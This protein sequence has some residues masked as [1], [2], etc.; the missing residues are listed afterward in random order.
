MGRT[1]TTLL[2]AATLAACESLDGNELG[3]RIAQPELARAHTG[4]SP[5]EVRPVTAALDPSNEQRTRVARA[6]NRGTGIFV[7]A[8]PER[9]QA[10]VTRDT[11]EGVTFNAENADVKEVVRMVLEDLLN[12][13][14]I[15]DPAIRG[16]ITIHTSR[17]V[18]VED[19]PAILDAVLRM[20]GAALVESGDLYKVVPIEKALAVGVSA[21]VAPV[22]GSGRP[23]FGV[24]IVPL[25]YVS[26]AEIA[27]LLQPFAYSSDSIQ[28]DTSRNLLLLAGGADQ[29]ETL[30]DLAAVF[31]VNWLEGM[32]FGLFPLETALVRQ[33]TDELQQ[34]FDIS[35]GG[36]LQGMLR[37]VPIERLNAVL[38]ISSQPSYL[39]QAAVWIERLDREGHGEKPRTYVYAVQNG[40]AADLAEVLSGIFDAHRRTVGPPNLL[41][42]GLEPVEL[43]SARPRDT[44]RT[45]AYPLSEAG[46]LS[47][48]RVRIIAD[49][50][51]NSLIIHARYHTFRDIRSALDKLDIR[52]LQVLIE[53]TIAEVTLRNEL[54]F[55]IDWFLRSGDAEV[56][57]SSLSSGAVRSGFPG[58]SAIMTGT[59]VVAVLNALEAV[60]DVNVISSPQIVVLDNQSAEL[61]VGDQVPIITQQAQS[62]QSGDAPIIQTIQ[63]VQTG[64]LLTVVPRVNASRLVT[65][66][67]KQEVSDAI[68][69]RT[70]GIDS[71]TIS[72][73]RITSTVAVQ[74][75]ETVALGGLIRD[76]NDRRLTGVPLLSRLPVIGPLFGVTDRG[77]ER[78]ELLVL[79]TPKVVGSVEEAR[80][81]TEELRRRIRAVAPLSEKL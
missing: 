32:S 58:F 36:P 17:P 19:L 64:V 77:A 8:P 3:R 41:R 40:R 23:G 26:A 67:I 39:E 54:R 46:G 66:E 22:S 1:C 71:P 38:V 30:K 60:T 35:E 16:N 74:S 70:S 33:L 69:T 45:D 9:T 76:N 42:P 25:R 5:Q 80:L 73:R 49:E 31:D 56:S 52:P 2:L 68:E 55:G 51:T 79:I 53:A 24:Q 21:D 29:L 44:E 11:P 20:N 75:G 62:V 57:F 27:R 48:D 15:I 4:Q 18:A 13:S 81:V 63:Q 72:Q 12:K 14:Y 43:H 65:L 50:T 78:T 28:V 61:Q 37:F 34:L 47:E 59:D 10:V 6:V 7:A